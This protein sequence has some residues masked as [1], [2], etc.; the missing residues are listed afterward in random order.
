MVL[1]P[2]LYIEEN[3]DGV[4]QLAEA[5]EKRVNRWSEI[6]AVG[7]DV[8][9]LKLGDVVLIPEKDE[10]RV[11]FPLEGKE[12]AIFPEDSVRIVQGEKLI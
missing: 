5:V 10:G 1:V 11:L 8:K 9:E 4:I 6:I 12:Y 7:P 3:P 2:I